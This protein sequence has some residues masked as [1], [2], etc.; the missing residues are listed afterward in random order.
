MMPLGETLRKAQK[1]S[2]IELQF[3]GAPAADQ[4]TIMMV[5]TDKAI[6]VAGYFF[7]SQPE[8]IVAVEKA[9]QIRP[10]NEDWVSFTIDPFH[11]HQF[12][13]RV[14]FMANPLAATSL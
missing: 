12:E 6:Y 7:D 2:S 4:S 9:D 1:I 14:F 11:T 8:G 5:Y 10:F 13:D 3:G